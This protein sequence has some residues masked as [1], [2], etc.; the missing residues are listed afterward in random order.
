VNHDFGDQVLL[1]PSA[2]TKKDDHHQK[3][4]GE[5]TPRGRNSRTAT[6]RK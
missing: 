3:K 4:A 2:R 5:G 1:S 6:P